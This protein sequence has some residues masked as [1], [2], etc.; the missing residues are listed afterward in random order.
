MKKE[1]KPIFKKICVF[2]GSIL[3]IAAVAFP[4]LWQY[5]VSSSAKKMAET[6]DTIRMLIPE[7][8]NAVL[9]ERRDNDMAIFSLEGT[10]YIGIL[11]IPR[12][13]SVLPV[14]SNWEKIAKN[15]CRFSGSAYD[16]TLII[17]G[18]SQEGQYDFYREISAGDTVY[19]TDMEGKRYSYEVTDIRYEKHADKS[20][21]EKK[22]AALT[23]FIKNIYGF[24]YVV[25]FCNPAG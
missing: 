11:E 13:G 12:Y 25:V 20:A 15:P 5:Y 21:L 4:F 16:R 8:Q 24:E 7:L 22:E 14:S 19:F 23:L 1:P 10:D 2:A 9:E 18:T 6:V 17:G 3:L